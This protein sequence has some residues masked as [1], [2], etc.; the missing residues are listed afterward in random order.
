MSSQVQTNYA[1]ILAKVKLFAGLERVDLARLAG[2]AES[3][4]VNDGI[5]V[6]RE[7]DKLDG[8]YVIARGTFGVFA[9]TPDGLGE[10]KRESLSPGDCFGD[11][12]LIDDTATAPTVRAE[13]DGE[14]LRLERNRV[15][16]SLH[17]QPATL[18]AV[19]A[20]LHR[21]Q[22]QNNLPK[23]PPPRQ[24][25]GTAERGAP[26]ERMARALMMVELGRLPPERLNR[27]L[28]A[29]V[30][31]E[32][33]LPALRL[34]FDE[35]ADQ[36]ARD[37][38]EL[39]I[40][41][42]RNS[43]SSLQT[44]RERFE[45]A[46]GKE[47]AAKFV[48]DAVEKLTG[49]QRWDE[50]L[51]ILNRLGDR[52]RLVKTLGQA[53]RDTPPLSGERVQRW[54]ELLTDDETLADGQ[55]L[56]VRAATLETQGEREAA[57]RLLRRGLGSGLAGADPIIGQQ[58]ASELS[59]LA[60]EAAKPRGTSKRQSTN[61]GS[62]IAVCISV[63]LA[64]IA[65]LLPPA[66]AQGKFL[67]LL[68]AALLLWIS[69][70][71]PEFAVGFGLAVSWILFGLAKPSQALA[72]F[73]SSNWVF[74]VS[75]LGLASAIARSGL[76]YRVG[77]LLV[78]RMPRSLLGQSVTLL[79]TGVILSPLLP[80]NKGRVTLT[81]PLALTLSDALRLKDRSPA[82]VVLGMAAW[83]GSTPLSFMFLNGG[84][85]TLLTWGLLPEASRSHFNW[86]YWFIAAAPLGLLA[87]VGTLASM[88]LVLRPK[89]TGSVS[90]DRVNLQL[91]V[92]GPLTRREMIMTLIIVVM[93]IGWIG[94]GALHLDMG[95]I[96]LLGV[97]ATVVA[98]IFD[99]RSFQQ[100]D[101]NYL[102]LFGVIMGI[103]G[104]IV[105]LGLDKTLA[106][107]VGTVLG[108]FGNQPVF[109]ILGVAGLSIFL[110]LI[111]SQ[112]TALLIIS[113]TLIPVAPLF[114]M[115]P[116]VIIAT[117]LSVSS[118]WFL[119]T[120]TTSYLLAY[121]TSEG[122]LFSHRQARQVS[123]IF[124]VVMLIALVLIVPYWRLLGLL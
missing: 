52:T 84:P 91:A 106:D 90:S 107:V 122:R 76:L 37:L 114:R 93:V 111:L 38:S 21:G 12:A 53:L 72:G 102:I 119:P 80:Q 123:F 92:L 83:V 81:T 86:I 49:A 115:E 45:Q 51:A 59:R 104:I 73:A 101:W 100:L 85:L 60:T 110:N 88:F 108:Q 118:M 41:R 67:L 1:G 78:R 97:L 35:A 26:Q 112:Q 124:A 3:Q 25:G 58:L 39:G 121:S 31:A 55:V 18:R 28:Q 98:G 64:S 34:L 10:V 57:A 2:H 5:T 13:G 79:L 94:A 47:T 9:L 46:Q 75:I 54:I 8:I 4:P 77:L 87:G 19:T 17:L 24:R 65:V 120:Q 71:L 99:K 113:V 40:R 70:V 43:E 63:F 62:I 50:A 82:S 6:C 32:V 27:V 20:I 66:N 56:L 14:L 89:V 95:M 105:S 16:E 42:D 117:A 44:L 22:A 68:P 103:S 36:V 11:I 116:W 30:L 48:W 96:A 61:R 29:S 7:G 33:S 109:V 23:A 15:I 74:V 69:G